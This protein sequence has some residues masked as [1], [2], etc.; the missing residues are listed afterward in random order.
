M[1]TKVCNYELQS[2]DSSFEWELPVKD[3]LIKKLENQV[4]I[5][6][7]QRDTIRIVKQHSGNVTHRESGLHQKI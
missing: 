7:I 3:P 5:Q 2:S 4:S 6:I 1:S